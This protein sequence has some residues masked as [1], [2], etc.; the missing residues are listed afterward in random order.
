[1]ERIEIEG[2]ETLHFVVKENGIEK[3]YP[4]ERVHELLD[5]FVTLPEHW[6]PHYDVLRNWG[7]TQ[8]TQNSCVITGYE[9]CDWQAAVEAYAVLGIS[10]AVDDYG[11]SFETLYPKITALLQRQSIDATL[12]LPSQVFPTKRDD[13]IACPLC[14]VPHS[15]NPAQLPERKREERYKFDLSGNKRGE[16]ED[17]SIQIMHVKPL[18]ETALLHSGANVRSGTVGAMSQ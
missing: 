12:K 3:S 9:A 6:L 10:V 5:R 18:T 7:D 13:I 11:V 14:K 17:G 4:A 16:G 2:G 15:Q 1:V 8:W